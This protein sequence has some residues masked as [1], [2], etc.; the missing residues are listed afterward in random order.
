[1]HISALYMLIP[2]DATLFRMCLLALTKQHQSGIIV[3]CNSAT[4]WN[5]TAYKYRAEHSS[6]HTSLHITMKIVLGHKASGQKRKQARPRTSITA[7]QRSILTR[8][9]E[10]ICFPSDTERSD[11]ASILGLS[12]R[13]IQ[14]W[15]QN[16][17]QRLCPKTAHVLSRAKKSGAV[18]QD[19]PS[20]TSP[21]SILVAA[22]GIL[23]MLENMH[24]DKS[25]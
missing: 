22:T 14:I 12:E 1:M 24:I 11:L 10:C 25:G 8:Y 15:F 17:R 4:C 23:T 20:A 9:F 19:L 16:A 2:D 5:C 6:S 7:K 21:L 3:C 13:T 18:A